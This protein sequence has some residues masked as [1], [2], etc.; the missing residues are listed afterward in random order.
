MVENGEAVAYL[1][2]HWIRE[3]A[4][5]SLEGSEYAIQRTSVA[6]GTFVLERDGRPIA[7]AEKP[8]VFRRAFEVRAGP[9]RWRLEATSLLGREF[10]VV[11]GGLELGTIRPVS[12]IR[13][14]ARVE[15]PESVPRP[16]QIFV[17]CLVLV[18]W[19]RR[20]DSAAAGS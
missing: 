19:K 3:R 11:R 20:A 17:A 9:E 1:D 18:L 10:R 6:R 2:R 4:S 5:F 14:E 8:S 13:R 7:E 16:L 15:L 12:V